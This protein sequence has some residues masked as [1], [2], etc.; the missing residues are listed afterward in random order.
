MP[1]GY[2]RKPAL[3]HIHASFTYVVVPLGLFF[4]T[5][6]CPYTAMHS[7]PQLHTLNK[8]GPINKNSAIAQNLKP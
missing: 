3:A 8:S 7:L 6:A 5:Q 2:A 1:A 4:P